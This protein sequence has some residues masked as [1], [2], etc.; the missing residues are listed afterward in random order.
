MNIQP[1]LSGPEVTFRQLEW[2]FG[3]CEGAVMGYGEGEFG[4]DGR[5]QWC[6]SVLPGQA[7]SHFLNRRRVSLKA[8]HQD[9]KK[10]FLIL[11]GSLKRA[12]DK[13]GVPEALF[14]VGLAAPYQLDA[15]TLL[16]KHHLARPENINRQGRFRWPTGVPL[17]RVWL[18]T[19]PKPFAEI[20]GRQ[21]RRFN[22]SD[23]N[24]VVPLEE[25]LPGLSR[26]ASTVILREAVSDRPQSL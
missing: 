22:S 18:S 16:H 20:I 10:P 17:L 24:R 9:E 21:H 23:G 15:T 8:A 1:A 25:L 26:A 5:L 3:P 19:P 6:A 7:M 14:G 4:A 13:G 12:S 11:L 2:S